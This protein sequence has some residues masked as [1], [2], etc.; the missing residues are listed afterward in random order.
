MGKN[1][2]SQKNKMLKIFSYI[3]LSF[4]YFSISNSEIIKD[5]KI[6][7]NKRVS[8]E[9]VKVY[10]EIK[11]GENY[12]EGDLNEI[13]TNLYKTDFFENI[14]INLK[15]NVLNIDLEEY[16][17]VNQLIVLGE[18]SKRFKDQLIK[19]IKT[20]EKNHL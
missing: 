5:V 19:L 10:G 11:I 17:V 20:K 7:G 2:N 4:F 14:Q 18:P 16:S 9:T 15:N 6:S 13:L 1:C 3:F 12:S 8:D